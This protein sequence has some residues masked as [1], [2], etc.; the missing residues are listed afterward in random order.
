MQT[1]TDV[2]ETETNNQNCVLKTYRG[3]Q[4][5]V[6]IPSFITEIGDKAFRRNLD[7]TE[8]EIPGSVQKIDAE[9]FNGCL[10][11]GKVTF[12]EGL[13]FI[14]NRAFWNCSALR[15]IEFP[16]TLELIGARAFECCSQLSRVHIKNPD[17]Y[18]DEN[19]FR[20][21]PYYD[22][23]VREAQKGLSTGYSRVRGQEPPDLMIPEGVT[24]VDLWEY[25]RSEI[26]TLFL[27]DSLRTVGMCAFKDC[28]KLEKVSMSP[29]TYC[30]YNETMQPKADEGIFAGCLALTDVELRGP[31][32]NFVWSDASTPELLHGFDPE[33]TFLNCPRMKRMT[34]FE[35]PLDRF[36]M[37]WRQ[38]ALNGYLADS[39]READYLPEIAE[40]YDEKLSKMRIQL[41]RKAVKEPAD[42]L[43]SYLM[44]H[45]MLSREDADEILSSTS[46]KDPEVA[47]S[48]I[49]YQQERFGNRTFFDSF[50]I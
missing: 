47:A 38:Y 48:L 40:Q 36:P 21:T 42:A 26:R 34:A 12:H 45:N 30:N 33:R 13:L 15:S 6:V 4:A 16:E 44:L 35:I 50:Q 18:L 37:E 11:L 43:C 28:K 41:V 46:E 39:D 27:P 32:K 7:L 23:Q 1:N 49:R 29:N 2:F 8:I 9:A 17:T 20:E 31:L 22:M 5:K 10:G 3:H 14:M 24:N 25:S 19:A